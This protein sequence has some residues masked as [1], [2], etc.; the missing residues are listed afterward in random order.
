MLDKKTVS[1]LRKCYLPLD[2][3][4]EPTEEEWKNGIANGIL[5]P[6]SIM[7]HDEI[8]FEIKLLSERIAVNAAA[9]AFLYSLS[10]ADLRYRT[11]ISSL[12][13]AKAL[14][15]HSS[16]GGQTGRS[17]GSCNICG[18]MYGLDEAEEIDFNYFGV[19]RYLPPT[20]YAGRLD[21]GR[22]EYVLNDLR[23]FEKLPAVE[24]VEEDYYILNR[25][26]GAITTLKSHN[27]AS[28]LVSDIRKQKII[29][30]TGNGIHCL[31]GVLSMCGI[32]E[33][34]EHK[35]YLHTFTGYND[36]E[37]YMDSD[38]FYPLDR[39]RAKFGVN[40]EAVQEV[41]GEFCGDKLTPD[42]AVIEDEKSKA[43]MKE[44]PAK[45][46][47][48]KAEQYFTEGEH[49]V[50]LNDRYRHFYGLSPLDPKWD[51]E[52]R[53]STLH[54]IYY[55][56]TELYYEGDTLKKYIYEEKCRIKEGKSKDDA[57][58]SSSQAEGFASETL[59]YE[60]SDLDAPTDSR[61]LLLPKT[62]KGRAKPI[63]PSLLRTPTY[64][65]GHLAISLS[66]KDG[67]ITSFNSSN[68]QLL[69]LPPVDT[70]SSADDFTSYTEKYIAACPDDYESILD[71]FRN[72]ERVT[73]KFSAGD[74][75]R[76][77]LTPTLYTYCLILCKVR[78]LLE[79]Q[80]VPKEHPLQK[81][82]CQPIAFRQYGIITDDPNMTAEQLREIP[83]LYTDYAQD[84]EILWETYP[85]VDH[86]QL[87]ESDLDFG[88]M[89]SEK[90]DYIVWDFALYPLSAR[91]RKLKK[92][93][94]KWQSLPRP[95]GVYPLN[96]SCSIGIDVWMPKAEKGMIRA[97]DYFQYHD[98]L[99]HIIID[100]LKLDKSAPADDFAKRFGGITRSDFIRLAK[101]RF[102][103]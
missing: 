15:G 55:R 63:N 57:S 84:N 21:F 69:P 50:E 75:F 86:K 44:Q 49:I 11:A 68:D 64:M 37:M 61:Q 53:Y 73:V 101:E 8:I 54:D 62:G 7:T 34:D 41:F 31:L 51:K 99:K 43:V 36:R 10:S 56:R 58:G 85:I 77:Q 12:F 48:S 18:C 52:V 5:V 42:K 1:V 103:K 93:L 60:E 35:G 4:R 70:L 33:T 90:D 13:W 81:I 91:D 89:I 29:N 6:V 79:W 26:F 92:A 72:K 95:E 65:L 23:E 3:D 87:T 32:L 30:T 97:E 88:V 94:K 59:F 40:Y 71:N 9:K 47:G 45:K 2:P 80:E 67:W 24:P 38:L 16:L 76:V 98:K 46:R 74:I 14:P 39:W 96:Y 25:I 83:L 82:M 28:A 66:E 17:Y 19:F 102:R 22:A 20:Q 27:K 78:Q 100:H